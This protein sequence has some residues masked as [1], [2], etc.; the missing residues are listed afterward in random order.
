MQEISN[1]NIVRARYVK[2]CE[3]LE[4][5]RRKLSPLAHSS[6]VRPGKRFVPTLD[7]PA[8]PSFCDRDR[9]LVG[10]WKDYL[11]WEEGNPI[12]YGSG[13]VLLSSTEARE[14]LFRRV[15]LAYKSA[16][17]RMCFYPEIW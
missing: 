12:E 15:H 16:V 7:L 14:Q 17:V 10:A 9:A 8:K 6:D 13:T 3:L 4:S 5:L 11:R 1:L 2:A